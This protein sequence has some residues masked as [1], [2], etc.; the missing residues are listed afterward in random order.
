MGMRN[1]RSERHRIGSAGLCHWSG[2]CPK[3][4]GKGEG[5]AEQMDVLEQAPS[6]AS[7][8]YLTVGVVSQNPSFVRHQARWSTECGILAYHEE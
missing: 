2:A 3:P 7:P 5:H 4:R 1:T 6:S 8:T